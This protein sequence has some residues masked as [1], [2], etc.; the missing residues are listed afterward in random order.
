VALASAGATSYVVARTSHTRGV[1]AA[2]PAVPE[3]IAF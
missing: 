3:L 1:H 2:I